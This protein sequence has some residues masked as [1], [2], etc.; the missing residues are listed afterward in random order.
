VAKALK[1][2][3]WDIYWIGHKKSQWQDK[4]DSAEY[5]EVTDSGIKFFDLKAGKIYRTVQPEKL[6]RLPWGFIHAFF[7]IL[8]LK[9]KLKSDL[10]GIVSFGGYLAVPVVLCGRLAGLRSVTHE[11]TLTAGW[12]NKVI[13]YFAEKIAI[14][15]PESS[16]Y[17]PAE[18]VVLTGLPVRKEITD[19]VKNLSKIPK[20]PHQI[21]ITG[22]KQ[23]SHAIN[24]AVFGALP[25]LLKKHRVIHQT[26]SSTVFGDYQKALKLRSALPAS[27]RLGYQV[28]DYLNSR[29][30][31][32]ILAGSEIVV[33]R[34]G[35]HIIQELGLFGTRCVLIPIPWSSH[36]EQLHNAQLL[37][38]H[39]LAIILPQSRL[40]APNLIKSISQAENL[41][42]KKLPIIENGLSNMTGLIE[43]TFG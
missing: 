18:K 6:I 12:A 3:G 15:W 21:Y 10:K 26:G 40:D 31:A 2:K 8:N 27:L 43:N 38:S 25:E 20:I 42:P 4:S 35:A 14:S 28:S 13:A 5:R 9:L 17:Y 19:T 34:S 32:G 30:V 33:S 37:A 36:Q 1:E 11:Q 24:T 23:G 16:K 41:K 39:N 29:D 7:I 22:G